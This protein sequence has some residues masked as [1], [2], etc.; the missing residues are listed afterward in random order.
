M[1]C[2][3]REFDVT[4][5]NDIRRIELESFPNY[6]YDDKI[7]LT[8]HYYQPELFIVAECDGKI[9][10]YACGFISKR[11]CG[12]LA[13]IAVDKQYRRKGIGSLLLASFEEKVLALGSRCVELEV[14]EDNIDAIRFYEKHGYKFV[15][16]LSRYYPDGKNALFMKK[17]MIS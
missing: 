10:G 12:H 1:E 14:S 11:G 4:M 7:F 8:L 3:V 6:P 9:V 5:L 16:T 17:T 15:K 2:R 13:S